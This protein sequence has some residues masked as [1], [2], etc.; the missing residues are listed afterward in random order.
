[1]AEDITNG[2]S[3]WLHLDI[4]HKNFLGQV[5]HWDNLKVA[6]DGDSVWVKDFTATQLEST[7]LQRIPFMHL[8]Y[9]KD[10]LLFPKGSLLPDRRQ[11]S[12][13]WT[14]IER[15]LPV[16]LPG[17]NHNCFGVQQK[18]LIRLVPMEEEQVATVLLVDVNIAGTYIET[19]PAARLQR[20]HW[21]LVNDTTALLMGEP[22]LPLNGKAYWQ[23]GRFILPVGFAF[24]FAALEKIAAEQMDTT[25]TAFIW[26]MDEQAYC[27]LQRNALQVLS[28]ASWRQTLHG[29]ATQ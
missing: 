18:Q 15:A 24:E 12:F 17:F 6:V 11:P 26:W 20:L 8:Y 10:N 13:L 19:A 25:G 29:K 28:I 14:P 4:K 1:M 16:T 2:L 27:L 5:R 23:K 3:W 21:T 9:C 7:A 22:L